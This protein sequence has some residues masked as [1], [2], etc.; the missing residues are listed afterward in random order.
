MQKE[1]KLWVVFNDAGRKCMYEHGRS[2]DF[3]CQTQNTEKKNNIRKFI[4][5]RK[6]IPGGKKL[7]LDSGAIIRLLFAVL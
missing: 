5:T 1:N 2:N 6:I 4:M 7:F 3:N